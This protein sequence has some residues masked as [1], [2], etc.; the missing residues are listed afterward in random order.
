M[1][2]TIKL[3][4]PNVGAEVTATDPNGDTLT[5]SL[6]GTD[7]GSFDI[8]QGM[9]QIAVKTATKLDLEAKPTYMVTVTATDPGGLSDSVNVTIKLT[10]EDEGPEITGD[11]VSRDY[12]ENGT[13]SVATLRATDPEGRPVYWSLLATT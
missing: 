6:G 4:Y 12:P 7:A 3:T 5:Y 10:D 11:D 1:V 8:N 9:G 13:G 2:P